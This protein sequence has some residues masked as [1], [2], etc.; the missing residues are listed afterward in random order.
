MSSFPAW[1]H[2]PAPGPD[3]T[4][5]SLI[6]LGTNSVRMDLWALRKGQAR[7][8]HREKRMVRL[9]DGLFERGRLE[10]A[11]IG[12]V[13]EALEDFSALHRV[14]Q[15]SRVRAVATAALREAPE[16]PALVRR[17]AERFGIDFSVISGAQEAAYIAQGVLREEA[18]PSGPY[19]LIDIGGGST[20]LSLCRGAKV[21]ES[22]SLPLGANRLQQTLLHKVPPAPGG[23]AALREACR[24]PLQHLP[25]ASRWPRVKELIGSGGTVRAVRKL[26]RAAGVKDQP[27]TLHVLSDL[28]R[29]MERLDR[30]GLLHIP[31]MDEK[32]VD[33]MLAGAL[34]LEEACLALGA[35]RIRATAASLRDGLLLEESGL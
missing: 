12:R 27:F 2:A 21:L 35:V 17:W 6:D 30:L 23:V 9:G 5:V 32:R 19:A 26:A 14:A 13:E 10:E 25:G 18:P 8:L 34:V 11:A 4:A 20:E 24:G 7:R 22:A 31:G 33:L 1:L 28:I 15:V 29:Q 3:E 16:A